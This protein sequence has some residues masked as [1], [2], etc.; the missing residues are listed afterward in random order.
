MATIATIT[1]IAAIICGLALI[2]LLWR[3]AERADEEVEA[4]VQR[5]RIAG[6]VQK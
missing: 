3:E 2:G 5:R 6:C 1:S 4:L